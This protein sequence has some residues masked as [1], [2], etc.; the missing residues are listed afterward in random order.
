M[1][2]NLFFPG[3]VGVHFRRGPTGFLRQDPSDEAKVIKG[4]PDL[5]DKSA[6][7]RED[8]VKE[9]ARSLV[10]VRGGDTSDK[11]EVL[12]E[13][14]LQ[15]G[16]YKGKSFRWLLEN[17]V[18]YT[19]YLI[20]KVEE[21]ERAGQ[22]HAEGPKKDSLL[23][24]LDYTKNFSEIGDLRNYLA[25][26]SVEPPAASEDD[27]L[28]GFGVHSKKTW[29]DVW[30]KREDGYASFILRKQCV[31]GS[32]MF[33]LQQYLKKK[34]SQSSSQ[35]VVP[36][37]SSN[38]PEMEDDEELESM[39]LSISPSKLLPLQGQ[40]NEVKK[41][42]GPT[43][44][45]AIPTQP[46]QAERSRCPAA[47]HAVSSAPVKAPPPPVPPE[48]L[49]LDLPQC[50][51]VPSSRETH[52]VLHTTPTQSAAALPPP[53]QSQ[54]MPAAPP[55][56]CYDQDVSSWNCS[57]QQRIWMKTEM[58][59]LGLWPGSPPVRHAMN[60]ISLWRNPP[61]PELIDS[62]YDLPSPKYFHLHPFFIWKPDHAIMERVR[63][64]YALPCLYGCSKPHVVS[65]GTGRPR[66]IIG[67][68]GQYYI[69]ASR[70]TCKVCKK[71]WFADKPA[72]MDMLPRRFQNIFPAFLT[73]KKAI[74]RTVM[75][76]L[77]RTAKSPGDMANQLNE[78]LHLKY[79]RAHVAYLSTV[80]NVLDGESG[81]YGQQTITGAVRLTST[82]AP[83][84]GY[85]DADGWCGV[86]VTS[87]YLV[88]C[89]IQE[90][91]REEGTLNLLLQGTF[92]EVLRA[93]HTRKVARKVVLASGTMSSYAVMNESWMILSWVMLQ[94]ESEKSL[95][96]MYEGLARRY[97]SADLP[98]AKYQWVDRD[99]C[100]AFRIPNSQPREHLLWDS[101][102][103]TEAIVAEATAGD[104][105]NT[106][107]SR[108]KYNSE[109]NIKLDLFHCMRRFTRECISEHHPLHSS[110]AKFLSAAFCVVDQADLQRL[111]EAYTFCGIL[112]ANPTKQHI[113]EHCRTMIPEPRELLVRVES[114]LKKFFLES[115]PDGV[116]LFKPSMLKVW[117][118]QR[119]HILRGCLSDP[120]VGDG[121]LYR[122]GGTVQLNHAKGEAAA[123]P[124]W[125][126]V[127]GTSQQEGFHFHQS[128]W[129]TGNHVSTELFQAQG[130]TGVA[131]WN[132]HR[133]VSLKKPGLK[134]PS[135]FNPSLIAELN[136]L[137]REVTGEAQYPALVL[138]Q[139]DTGE[140]FGLQY[141]EPGCRPVPLHWDKHKSQRGPVAEEQE[142]FI[143]EPPPSE[144]TVFDLPEEHIEESSALDNFF[145]VVAEDSS[146]M[147]QAAEV[148]D[149]GTPPPLPCAAFPRAART[150]PVKTGGLLFVLDHSR[151]TNP[152]RD[153]IDALL[154]KFHG[155]KDFLSKV[156]AEYAALVQTSA[157]NP[158]SLLHPTTKQHISRY[159]KHKA[160]MI[161]KSS[162]LNTSPE[163]LLETQQLWHNL[164]EGSETVTV[165][166]VTL[167]PAPV[168]P[169]STKP[170]E[171]P[172]T[173][174]E[175]E[176][177][178]KELVATQQQ[179][180][181]S[182]KKMTKNCLA[183]GQPK[184]RYL[185]D[186][187]SVHFFYQSG[188]VKY[189][190]CSKK[191]QQI[192]A[193]EGLNNPRMAFADFAVTP[194]FNR[195]LEAAKQRSDE[196]KKVLEE[197]K[198]RKAVEQPP[199]G[200]LCRFCHRPLRQG[201]GSPH[202]HTGFPG[203][204]GKYVYCPSKV[205]SLHQAK[206]MTHEMSWEE[207]SQSPFYEAEKI[208]WTR[209]GKK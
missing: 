178:V 39:M 95:E 37:A 78:A 119:V 180:Q 143:S 13:Y 169:P 112:P 1:R 203:V 201:P 10:F 57:P 113:R 160:K 142:H 199:S 88:E 73:H 2:K 69:L 207:F 91:H 134:L 55:L 124:I 101:W 22:F 72:W 150:G 74:C 194:F 9:N 125:I 205:L 96:P 90:Y 92:G 62:I 41:M 103:T 61:Q 20:N 33:L 19:I 177:M 21:E 162:S 153:T 171:A 65:S 102:K 100:S 16:R 132:F 179:Q 128:R 146:A 43:C 206:G 70:L 93:D 77:R 159:M 129:V 110:F 204:P 209:K 76:E 175:I 195:E 196:S 131:R 168:N 192:Y 164:T 67:T 32:K 49:A 181:P 151:W 208:R 59:A 183:C 79:E 40:G 157:R 191:V 156:D 29:R 140:R 4:N 107:A 47:T 116:P 115:D 167:P 118:I 23:S 18:G 3:K 98:K 136:A 105:T 34:E 99:C 163:K 89:L 64:N 111:K 58:E 28:V 63:N 130:M 185:G 42:T 176:K 172:L 35:A 30:E 12:G 161:N 137:S 108:K 155:Q 85:S 46:N 200:R 68:S 87:H 27:R 81:L 45:L 71:H 82:P 48:L 75:D 38:P 148:K 83:F 188:D 149:D 8:K 60:M 86:A 189:F 106:C 166:V 52:T 94:S 135:V 184:S 141:V 53:A 54:P 84:G 44:A 190:Y 158:N 114:V 198:K 165:P 17:D 144:E 25:D 36:K 133:L 24:F 147:T 123:V 174:T 187:S 138:S 104:T 66:V 80:K 121:I 202:V 15:F 173:K 193:A 31:E 11:Q 51:M 154:G 109:I 14:I 182:A 152:M 145:E 120:Q 170:D 126:P 117:R 26:R 197:R 122:H 7:Q 50:G 139:A 6:P 127:R 186:G 5:Q 56:P 97:V